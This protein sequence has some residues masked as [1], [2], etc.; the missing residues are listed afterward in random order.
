[1]EPFPVNTVAITVLSA[2]EV[3]ILQEMQQYRD[4]LRRRFQSAPLACHRCNRLKEQGDLSTEQEDCPNCGRDDLNRIGAPA[5]EPASQRTQA[6]FH[7]VARIPQHASSSPESVLIAGGDYSDIDVSDASGPSG[8]SWSTPTWESPGSSFKPRASACLS[9]KRL[10]IKCIR[11]SRGTRCEPCLAN[12]ERCF[13]Q[14][15]SPRE[16]SQRYVD[17]TPA[18]DTDEDITMDELGA[19]LE[20]EDCPTPVEQCQR[21]AIAEEP[22]THQRA[23]PP[24]LQKQP[25]HPPGAVSYQ[26]PHGDRAS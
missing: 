20:P 10:K 18:E 2:E 7:R 21:D 3:Q 25:N 16:K 24:D 9:C 4:G 8:W 13:V 5:P 26:A 15:R 23:I 17:D 11:R 6:S 19:Y 14:A 12:H 22:T 1:M